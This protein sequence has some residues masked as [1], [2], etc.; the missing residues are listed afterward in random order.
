VQNVSA[1]NDLGAAVGQIKTGST[2][3]A[4]IWSDPSTPVSLTSEIA[5]MN[6]FSGLAPYAID[7]AGDIVGVGGQGGVTHAFL[8]ATPTT[9][10]VSVSALDQ[11]GKVFATA[12][13]G[14]GNTFVAK[15]TVTNPADAAGSVSSVIPSAISVPAALK[16]TAA[17][18]GVP[19]GGF[20]LAPGQSASFTQ[21]FAI[22]GPGTAQ[23]SDTIA[24][25]DSLGAPQTPISAQK[26]FDLGSA[27]TGDGV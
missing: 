7:D 13:E 17:P 14:V 18:S 24:Y 10:T 23:V 22:V 16:A 26:L 6:G 19:A 25:D 12:G 27:V 9:P 15:V 11:A 3:T 4:E 8:L 20:T 1:V 2:A 21:P 5:D